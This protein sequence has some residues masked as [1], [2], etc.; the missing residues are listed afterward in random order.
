VS[1]VGTFLKEGDPTSG[2]YAVFWGFGVNN[3]VRT[4]SGLA[5]NRLPAAQMIG[6]TA[7]I[8]DSKGKPRINSL[9]VNGAAVQ[10]KCR[11]T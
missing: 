3:G 11:L 1:G 4:A 6:A 5:A 8:L 2:N 10:P 7:P 9:R